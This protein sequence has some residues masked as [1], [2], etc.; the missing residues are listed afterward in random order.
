[1]G[2]KGSLAAAFTSCR[3]NK[4]EIMRLEKLLDSLDLKNR[5]SDDQPAPSEI[6]HR[7]VPIPP[8][9][10][11]KKGIGSKSSHDN[12]SVS[13]ESLSTPNALMLEKTVVQIIEAY[14]GLLTANILDDAILVDL[15][16]NSLAAIVMSEKLR[17]SH[18]VFVAG[19]D[20]LNLSVRQLE[21]RISLLGSTA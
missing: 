19:P 5:D 9:I 3:F 2:E 12:G 14:T 7:G 20:P 13:D 8:V 17:T 6:Q 11:T 10:K 4:L 21:Q 18:Q 16:L 1:L 15:G